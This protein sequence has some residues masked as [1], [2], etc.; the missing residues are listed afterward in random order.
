M[1]IKFNNDLKEQIRGRGLAKVMNHQAKIHSLQ[2]KI[3]AYQAKHPK[4]DE[5]QKHHLS[6]L[7]LELAF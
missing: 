5:K 3:Q 7:W 6:C 4:R 1:I 2:Q